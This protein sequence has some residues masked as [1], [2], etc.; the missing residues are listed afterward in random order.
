VNQEVRVFASLNH[1]NIVSYHCSW[2]EFDLVRVK[3]KKRPKTML[4]EQPNSSM[5]SSTSDPNEIHS[6]S[7]VTGRN[8]EESVADSDIVF[9]KSQVEDG[10]KSRRRSS[11]SPSNGVQIT[12]VEDSKS[13]LSSLAN[14][15]VGFCQSYTTADADEWTEGF[16]SA[17]LSRSTGSVLSG[18]DQAL[19]LLSDKSLIEAHNDIFENVMVL[20][21]QMKLCDCTLKEW[22]EKRN[23]QI[24]RK[25]VSLDGTIG[26]SIFRQILSG[27]E[28]IH[29]HNIIHRDLK[30]SSFLVHSILFL[31]ASKETESI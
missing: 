9:E 16:T 17:E 29:S 31:S 21:I 22:L 25:E 12:E 18:K 5:S 11:S 14:K 13:S 27:V 30:V 8:E 6:S 19:R 15:K 28:Y 7:I 3:S 2:V 1:E 26:F 24:A 4:V 23:E 10:Q 20:Y